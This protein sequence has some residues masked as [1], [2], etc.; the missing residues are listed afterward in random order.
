M[1]GDATTALALPGTG[2]GD[3]SRTF[4]FTTTVLD[5]NAAQGATAAAS[6]SWGAEPN[7]P[8]GTP[9]TPVT[10]P[11]TPTGTATPTAT[12]TPAPSISPTSGG[13]PS[14]TS[15]PPTATSDPGSGGSGTDSVP[16]TDGS[17]LPTD[18]GT[19]GATATTDPSASAG[20]PSV[21][22]DESGTLSESAL[23]SPGA[24]PGSGSPSAP[25]SDRISGAGQDS[26][27][28]G[29]VIGAAAAHAWHAVGTAA[30]VVVQ[31]APAAMRGGAFGLGTFPFLLLF[32]LLQR[33]ID[34]RDPK[35]A[36]APA[37]ADAYLDFDPPEDGS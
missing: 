29:A 15:T 7:L 34:H 18:T 2:V 31:D 25:G 37:H 30:R 3:G 27:S 12:P 22:P 16:A 26:K 11:V 13:Q 20:G 9:T 35:L 1:H 36:L 10:V 23:P 33:H 21:T 5:D 8:G 28:V 32:L 6:F 17:T 24:T 14:Q 4:R 19:P